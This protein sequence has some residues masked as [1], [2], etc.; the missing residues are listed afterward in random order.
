M[1][2]FKTILHKFDQKGEKTRWTYIE[3][4]FEIANQIKPDSKKGYRV[5][6]KIDVLVLKMVALLPMGEGAFIIPI[7]GEMRKIIKKEAGATVE[8]SLEEDTDEF[9]LSPDMMA[10]LEQEPAALAKFEKLP[11]SHQKYYSKWVESAKTI[12]T[13]SKRIRM[14]L[15]GFAMGMDFGEMVRYYKTLE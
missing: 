10:C 11:G 2:S 1:V 8:V 9:I 4:P 13:K 15:K 12:E 5:K 3:I 14:V 6:G 7:N